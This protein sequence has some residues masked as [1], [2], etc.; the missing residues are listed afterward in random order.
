MQLWFDD[1]RATAERGQGDQWL[2]Q[3]RGGYLATRGIWERSDHC[4]Y[5]NDI[6]EA[7]RYSEA[8]A[9]KAEIMAPEKYKAVLLSCSDPKNPVMPEAKAIINQVVEELESGFVACRRCGDQEDTATLDCMGDL[10]TLQA[11]LAANPG[12]EWIRCSDIDEKTAERVARAF[13]RRIYPYRNEYP[14][15]LPS[16]CPVEF[17]AN[18][19]TALGALPGRVQGEQS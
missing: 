18:M 16:P 8:E 3:L 1:A 17:S 5:T 4:G 15:E 19:W 13:W 7:G 9:K 2:I 11:L 12:N 10:R 6:H 14:K